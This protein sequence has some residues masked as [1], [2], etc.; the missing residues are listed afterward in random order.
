M[1]GAQP[2]GIDIRITLRG[3]E[4]GVAEQL[5]DGPQIA[6]TGEEVRRETVAQRVR[7]CGF[8]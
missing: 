4:A 6:A 3:R 8:G 2:F 1:H 5:L 7:C